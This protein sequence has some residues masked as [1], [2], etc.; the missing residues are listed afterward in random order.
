[1]LRFAF[2]AARRSSVAG[3][4]R[5]TFC[6]LGYLRIHMGLIDHSRSMHDLDVVR[7]ASAEDAGLPLALP[8]YLSRWHMFRASDIS[9]SA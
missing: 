3:I 8:R 1:M 9:F 7:S 6:D 5:G 2:F 4:F